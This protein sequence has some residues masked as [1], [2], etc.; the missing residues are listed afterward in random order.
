MK[1]QAEIE[2]TLQRF[3]NEWPSRGSIVDEVLR[4]IQVDAVALRDKGSQP[5]DSAIDE[6]SRV[7]LPPDRPRLDTKHEAA[8]HRRRMLRRS[9]YWG[10]GFAAA[11]AV[12]ATIGFMIR[13]Q[14]SFADVAAEVFKQPWIHVQI[15][16][17]D[18]NKGESWCSPSKEITAWRF[19]DSIEYRDYRLHVYHSYDLKEQVLYRGPDLSR[20]PIDTFEPMVMA[21]TVLAKEDRPADK[22]LEHLGFLGVDT[23]KWRVLDQQVEKVSEDGRAWLDYRM[24]VADP[25]LDQP[26]RLLFRVD[27]TNRL[28][29]MCRIEGQWNGKPATSETRF[30]YPEKG[31]GDVYDLGVPKTAKLVDRLPSHD[32]QKI[33]EAL[34]AGRERMDNYRAVFVQHQE[35]TDYSWWCDLPMT[36]YRKG[37]KFRADYVRGWKGDI[38]AVERPQEGEDLGKW[39]RKRVEF[40]RWYPQYVVRGSIV[41]TTELKKHPN[42]SNAEDIAAV[43]KHDINAKAGEV[44]PPDYSMR[45][46][47]ACRPP[48][49]IGGQH[50][51][52]VLDTNP[53]DGP[54]GCILLKVGHT[55]KKNRINDKGLGLPDEQRFWLDPKRDYIVMRWDMVVRDEDGEETIYESDT[56]EE[57]AKSPQGVWYV[58]QLRR[59]SPSRRTNDDFLDQVY[60]IYVDFDVD[61]PDSFFDPQVPGKLH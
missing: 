19:H 6:D 31:P 13:P 30:D 47:F 27:V 51:D 61:L 7:E 26:I 11:A 10:L 46:E 14:T 20:H 17:P 60:H 33:L 22:P 44:F 25:K 52:P 16:S 50:F 49:G 57:V 8:L 28:P 5:A 41:Y 40:F 58:K 32:I 56:M 21:L 38:D 3:G 35:P 9:A 37:D 29:R 48:L 18:G 24:T 55:T 23:M 34:R 2:D 45:P 54:P 53:T 4:R 12:A 43:A 39:W 1:S 59:Q 15:T 36:F 42:G